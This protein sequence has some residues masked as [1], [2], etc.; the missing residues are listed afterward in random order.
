MVGKLTISWWMFFEQTVWLSTLHGFYSATGSRYTSIWITDV[1]NMG[2]N[3]SAY[4]HDVETHTIQTNS[5]V[6]HYH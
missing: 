3:I 2:C 5:T 1:L 6:L 4:N